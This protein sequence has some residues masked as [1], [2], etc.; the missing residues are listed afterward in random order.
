M[1]RIHIIFKKIGGKA[2]LI[3]ICLIVLFI[4]VLYSIPAEATVYA[5]E[6]YSA[7]LADLHKDSRFN[8]ANY[9]AKNMAPTSDD[10]LLDVIS[11]GESDKN[12]LFVYVY[13]PWE[14]VTSIRAT[15][16]NISTTINDGISF[17]NYKLTYLNGSGVFAKYKVDGFTVKGDKTR[18]Y[19]I[20]SIYRKFDENIDIQASGGNTITEVE[21]DVSKQFTFGEI[22][23]NPYVEVV[24]IETIVV[25][26]KYVGFCR[27]DDGYRLFDFTGSGDSHF[28][29]FSTNR[30]IEKL[31]EADVYYTCQSWDYLK[32][33]LMGKETITFGT[34]EDKYAYLTC[35][36]HGGYNS[37]G[38]FFGGPYTWDR[39]QTVDDFIATETRNNNIYGGAILNVSVATRLTAEGLKNIKNKKWVLRFTE[40]ESEFYNAGTMSYT[41]GKTTIIG[42]VSILRLKFETDGIT[43]NMG[44][45]D[46]KQSGDWKTPDNTT[47]IVVSEGWL[48]SAIKAGAK[49]TKD[50]LKYILIIL[51]A[52]VLIVLVVKVIDWIVGKRKE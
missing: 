46:N 42:D 13:Q 9:P 27:Y 52:V 34:P 40:T 31:L 24:E 33:N 43:Y 39:I 35:D 49:A 41:S 19:V 5:E 14:N 10:K 16:I 3:S 11:F 26:D 51:V 2:V 18:Y 50:W 28:V 6:G 48:V 25:T 36:Q 32:N 15:S 21:N 29:A 17:R 22:N 1:K 38:L 12:E 20:T 4:V 44:V 8:E 47:E 30:E 7:V 37:S 45:I 23:G